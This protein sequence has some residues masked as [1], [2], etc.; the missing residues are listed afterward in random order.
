VKISRDD[1]TWI[2]TVDWGNGKKSKLRS[3]TTIIE[4]AFGM[5]RGFSTDDL[6]AMVKANE[7]RNSKRIQQIAGKATMLVEKIRN[8]GEF[9]RNAHYATELDDHGLLDEDT[10]DPALMPIVKAW[11]RFR[12]DFDVEIL[13][14]EVKMASKLGFAGSIDRIAELKGKSA[15]LD[16]KTREFKP[17]QDVLQTAAYKYGWEEMTGQKLSK[18]VIVSLN[19]DGTYKY[20]ENKGPRD[21]EIFRC[22]LALNNWRENH[23]AN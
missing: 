14:V 12:E 13:G 2:Y 23:G 5:Y 10:L 20:H 18:R 8:A 11:R 16:I 19:T 21:F 3:V 15:L 22:A 6:E 4:R 7:K 17:V 1:K 9:G